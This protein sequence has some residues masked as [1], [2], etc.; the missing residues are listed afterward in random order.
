[1]KSVIENSNSIVDIKNDLKDLLIHLG[2]N[3]GNNFNDY[4]GIFTDL[5]DDIDDVSR[6]ILGE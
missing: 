2:E 3:P 1:M 4:A 5:L 6:Q